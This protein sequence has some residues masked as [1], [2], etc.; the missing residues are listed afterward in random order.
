MGLNWPIFYLKWCRW[1]QTSVDKPFWIVF[2]EI[3]ALYQQNPLKNIF[4]QRVR[5]SVCSSRWTFFRFLCRTWWIVFVFQEAF[6][7]M[8]CRFE[9]PLGIGTFWVQF[10]FICYKVG[11]VGVL[12]MKAEEHKTWSVSSW[13]RVQFFRFPSGR[14]LFPN[15]PA[16]SSSVKLIKKC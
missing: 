10:K 7:F 5:A 1:H 16:F 15:N 13:K 9:W 14:K 8:K 11:K 2:K 4:C 6:T 3:F 12:I